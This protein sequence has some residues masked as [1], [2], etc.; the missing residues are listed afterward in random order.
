MDV[1]DEM[2]NR[3]NPLNL[4]ERVSSQHNLVRIGGVDNSIS[5]NSATMKQSQ[6]QKNKDKVFQLKEIKKQLDK[7]FQDLK[8]AVDKM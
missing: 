3:G 7:F 5:C 8:D 6:R 4:N 1:T 2:A